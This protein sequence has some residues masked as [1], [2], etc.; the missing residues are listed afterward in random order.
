MQKKLVHWTPICGLL[1]DPFLPLSDS[2]QALSRVL[3]RDPC[4]VHAYEGTWKTSWARSQPPESEA[5]R[6]SQTRQGLHPDR[7]QS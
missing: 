1:L 3:Q 6:H 7:Q 2:V 5:E 4:L